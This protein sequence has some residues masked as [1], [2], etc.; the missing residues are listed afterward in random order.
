MAVVVDQL[1]EAGV[2]LELWESAAAQQVDRRT[3][4]IDRIHAR[5]GASGIRRGA[6]SL[7]VA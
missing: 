4:A 6:G 1:V 3:E 5:W 7:Q 2:Q